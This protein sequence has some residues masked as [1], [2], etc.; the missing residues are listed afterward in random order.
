MSGFNPGAI[1]E[2][3]SSDSIGVKWLNPVFTMQV[4]TTDARGYV[5]FWQPIPSSAIIGAMGSFQF[6]FYGPSNCPIVL[7][8]ALEVTIQF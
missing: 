2:S 1:R 6:G 4:L 7:S 3:T 5:E 8:D